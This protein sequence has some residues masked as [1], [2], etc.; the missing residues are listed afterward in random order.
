MR[1][2]QL[3]FGKIYESYEDRFRKTI[4]FIRKAAI[5]DHNV[6]YA[7]G[8]SSYELGINSLSDLFDDE[9]PLGHI[10]H[11]PTLANEIVEVPAVHSRSWW[12]NLPNVVPGYF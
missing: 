4:Y 6:L 8:L 5:E 1:D 2:F 12:A 9:L 11:Q 10:V 7:A 3:D